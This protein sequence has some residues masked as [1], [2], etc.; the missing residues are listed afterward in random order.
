[1][2][3]YPDIEIYLAGADLEALNAWLGE[4]LDAAPLQPAGKRKWRGRG[5]CAGEAIPVLLVEGVADGFASL[6]LDSPATP[7]PRDIDLAREAVQ[8]L[9]CEVRCSLGGWQP[10][11]DPDRFW[12][13]CPNGHEG[14]IDWPDSGQ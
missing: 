4:R 2:E 3:R 8:R 14:P 1:M 10:G 13:V 11:D 7:W 12:Q 5:Y 6:W 9:G